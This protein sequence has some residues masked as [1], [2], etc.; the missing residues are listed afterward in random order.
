MRQCGDDVL[1]GDPPERGG[2]G[3]PHR[4]ITISSESPMLRI[5]GAG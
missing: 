2:G 1:T 4:I 5:T 3:M